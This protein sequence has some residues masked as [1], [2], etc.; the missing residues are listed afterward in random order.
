MTEN[1]AIKEIKYEVCHEKGVSKRCHDHCMY[2]KEKCAYS[3]SI[4]ALEEVQKY[5]ELGTFEELKGLKD[6]NLSGRELAMIAVNINKLKKYQAIG[7][8]EEC[9]EAR[10]RQRAKKPSIIIGKTEEDRLACCPVCESNLDW[11]YDGFWRK[12]N[13]KY[14]SNCGQAI[15]WSDTP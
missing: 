2:G 15:D 3:M 1:E 9:R 6:G 4:K 11:T 14:C 5:R 12:G 8:V 10:E 7:T 13:P